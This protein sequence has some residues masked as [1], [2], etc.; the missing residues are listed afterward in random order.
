MARAY[1]AMPSTYLHSTLRACTVSVT[2]VNNSEDHK[3]TNK[4]GDD[5]TKIYKK[6][7]KR[8]RERV[9]KG[10]MTQSRWQVPLPGNT[11]SSVEYTFPGK[12]SRTFDEWCWA[13]LDGDG[14]D[15]TTSYCT[16]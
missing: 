1:D 6:N 13:G 3:V 7:N 12:A 2:F 4:D 5:V 11:R 10:K 15:R 16:D 14:G 9:R 8:E